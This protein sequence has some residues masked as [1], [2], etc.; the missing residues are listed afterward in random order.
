MRVR[1]VLVITFIF[2]LLVWVGA[3]MID[4][5]ALGGGPSL[6]GALITAVPTR[7]VF[8]RLFG[9][10]AVLL[11]G[12]IIARAIA[13]RD[14]A[15]ARAEHLNAVLRA[16]RDVN[17]LI[18]QEKDRSRLIQKACE[19]LASSHGCHSVWIAL[20]DESGR[21]ERAAQSGLPEAPWSSLVERLQRGELPPCARCTCTVTPAKP[22]SATPCWSRGFSSSRSLSRSRRWRKRCAKL[23]VAV[24][25]RKEVQYDRA[26]GDFADSG[27]A[28]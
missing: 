17:Q 3:A 13:Q 25:C 10:S 26:R 21:L 14:Q 16:V 6:W 12:T 23:Y 2:A 20:F 19:H 4:Y 7:A 15:Q 18:T 28:P 11:L 5:F 8:A 22:S 1:G 27:G 24:P 9:S